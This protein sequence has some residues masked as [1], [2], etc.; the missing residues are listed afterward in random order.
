MDKKKRTRSE[1]I[2]D[3]VVELTKK[4]PVLNAPATKAFIKLVK[5]NSK[6][7]DSYTST[8]FIDMVMKRQAAK[9]AGMSEEDF[10]AQLQLMI[11]KQ[12]EIFKRSR[13]LTQEDLDY[14]DMIN[15]KMRASKEAAKQDDEIDS[16][17]K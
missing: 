7:I 10:K 13:T 11:D 6:M 9:F 5:D 15:A 2:I 8:T 16:L 1:K 17:L 12:R 14:V 3:T 4:F